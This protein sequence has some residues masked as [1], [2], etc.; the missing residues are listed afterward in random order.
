MEDYK[1][2]VMEAKFAQ[3]MWDNEPISSNELVKLCEKV[4][5]WKKSTTYTMLRRL[6]DRGIFQNRDGTVTSLMSK[7]KF[8]ALQSER[9]VEETFDGSL[10]QFLAAFTLRKKLSEKE[11]AELQ[12]L[13]DENRGDS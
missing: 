4:L 5:S 10:P 9:F 12:R 1:L 13:I 2:G 7:Q 8:A 11:I 3:L 6:C